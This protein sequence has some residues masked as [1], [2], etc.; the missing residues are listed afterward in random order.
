MLD[1]ATNQTFF[2]QTCVSNCTLDNT[3]I[4]CCQ[5]DDCN[6]FNSSDLP[7]PIVSS[8]Y[9]GVTIKVNNNLNASIQ[10]TTTQ[11]MPPYD[12][13]CVIEKDFDFT[14]TPSYSL[15]YYRFDSECVE[16]NNTNETN[17]GFIKKCCQI[18]NCNNS[19][20]MNTNDTIDS[21]FTESEFII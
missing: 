10:L 14:V 6:T 19:T 21:N 12:Q 5:T 11:T 20:L 16:T 17:K 13:Y 2:T 18:D 7:P 8:C 9:T 3:T 1:S 4:E 15:I